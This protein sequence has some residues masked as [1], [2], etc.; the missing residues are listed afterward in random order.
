MK[1]YIFGSGAQGRVIL[2]I[3]RVQGRHDFIEFI[4]DNQE[5]WGKQV[6]GVPIFGGFDYV[7]EQDRDSFEM[8]IALGNPNTRLTIAKKAEDHSISL[9]NAVHPASV[10]MPTVTIGKGNMISPG[11]V[12]N[13]NARIGN[14]V[15]INTSAVIEH[16]SQIEDGATVCPGAKICGRAIIKSAAFIS[17]GAIVLPRVSIGESAVIGSGAIVVKDIPEKVFALGTPA[18]IVEKID[19]TFDWKRLL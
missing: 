19:E 7:I 5:L 11:S 12:I 6:N 18:R 3:L 15:I 1:A 10:I 4:D 2:D 17:T 14:N 8:V 13:T 16:D 9:L